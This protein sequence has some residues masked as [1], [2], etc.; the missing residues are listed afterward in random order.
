MT[1]DQG[2][3]SLSDNQ[4]T[5]NIEVSPKDEVQNLI[6]AELRKLENYDRK[7][8]TFSSGQ[9]ARFQPLRVL[10]SELVSPIE[11]EYIK[12]SILE[13]RATIEV[14]NGDDVSSRVRWEIEP[15]YKVQEDREEYWCLNLWQQQTSLEAI[16]G[17]KMAEKRGG[18]G[19][20]FFVLAGESEVIQ[21]ISQ[22]IAKR[23]AFYRHKQK[24]QAGL[25]LIIT[26]TS[27]T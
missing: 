18:D 11:P 24:R 4:T 17:F 25:N 21:C 9:L 20:R 6:Q 15:N 12:A 23:V 10:L 1:I 3:T 27:S 8:E 16:P 19:E 26:S 22:E 13:D 5:E 7:S 2:A 14:G